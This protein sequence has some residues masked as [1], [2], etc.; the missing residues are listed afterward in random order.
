MG[1][2]GGHCG[3]ATLRMPRR[4]TSTRSE[5]TRRT[6]TLLMAFSPGGPREEYFA[7]VATV[8]ERDLSRLHAAHDNHLVDDHER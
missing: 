6:C 5:G 3:P 2:P 1:E 8:N 4:V 7:Q